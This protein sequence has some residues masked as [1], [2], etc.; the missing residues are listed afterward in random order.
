LDN[1][2]AVDQEF[3]KKKECILS[4]KSND[5][6][7][8]KQLGNDEETV[9]HQI[10]K[11]PKL[12][13]STSSPSHTAEPTSSFMVCMNS[14]MEEMQAKLLPLVGEVAAKGAI[15]MLLKWESLRENQGTEGITSV[16]PKGTEDE[17]K[18]Y[19]F[20]LIEDKQ[21][22]K[23]IHELIK[24]DLFKSFAVADTIDRCVRIWHILFETQMPNYGKF[25]K[26]D[27]YVNRSKE[28]KLQ[29]PANRP[30]YLRFVLYKENIDTATA[31]KDVAKLVRLAPKGKHKGGHGS[32]GGLGYAGMK[33]KRACTT[34]F[35]TLY[36]KTA[37]ELMIL[38][39]EQK[40][41]RPQGGGN[42]KQG[43]SAIIRVGHFCFVDKDIRLG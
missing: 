29:W 41:A 33:D 23:S 14:S 37:E 4:E 8:L 5:N 27:R 42:S 18:Y 15:G 34:Q 17:S 26:D 3:E 19:V 38:N 13:K 22:R 39:R 43:G 36:R 6:Q 12:E 40:N 31:A 20:P 16:P 1:N 25:I 30:N 35:C 11:K 24:S 2:L 28:A 7:V 9:P 32:G 10:T 21:A